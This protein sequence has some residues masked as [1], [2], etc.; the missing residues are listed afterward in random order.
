MKN[1]KILL[2][3]QMVQIYEAHATFMNELYRDIQNFE[4]CA[5]NTCIPRN[6]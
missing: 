1:D 5:L 3:G 4:R 2:L 6:D